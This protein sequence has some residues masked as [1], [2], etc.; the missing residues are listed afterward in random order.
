[1]VFVRKIS[2]ET[3]ALVRFLKMENKYSLG[4]I[5]K[6]VKISKSSVARCLKTPEK[7]RKNKKKTK[8]TNIGRPKKLSVRDR[9]LLKR[10]LNQ[11]R[12]AKANFT[13]KELIG[14]S[15]LQSSGASY[16][17]FYREIK[18]MGFKF[19]NARKK[20]LLNQSDCT[21]QYHF[22]KKCRKILKVKPN[23]FHS[24]I[25]FYWDRVSFVFKRKPMQ[26][27]TVP[28]GKIWRKRSEGLQST[29]KGSNDLPGGKR[30]H[31]LVAI[32]FNRGIVLAQDYEHMTGKYFSDFVR[33]NLS[34]LFTGETE[35][36]WLWKQ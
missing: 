4:E 3:R 14:F 36:K 13:L 29:S 12:D 10:S 19:L 35:Q 9:R 15:G 16:S 30:L 28:K 22:A 1:M 20:G 2:D 26:D 31:F 6:K 33:K 21:K 24:N 25:S 27:A 23:L 18:T 5:A 7:T 34:T 11:L 17:T 8:L 32:A